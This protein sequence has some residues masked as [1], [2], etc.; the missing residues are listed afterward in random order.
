MLGFTE[1]RDSCIDRYS[2]FT[3]GRSIDSWLVPTCIL[4]AEDWS[5]LQ[6]PMRSFPC[7]GSLGRQCVTSA[8]PGTRSENR[9]AIDPDRLSGFTLD[10]TLGGRGCRPTPKLVKH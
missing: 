6:I 4:N 5:K 2:S 9:T 7:L 3:P 10:P 8:L 1:A